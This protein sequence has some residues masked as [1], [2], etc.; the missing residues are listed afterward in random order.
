SPVNF[1]TLQLPPVNS[2]TSPTCH[3]PPVN[4]RTSPTCHLSTLGLPP[5]FHLSTPPSPLDTYR[6]IC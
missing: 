3:L 5:T 2:R 4:S 6:R 1:P